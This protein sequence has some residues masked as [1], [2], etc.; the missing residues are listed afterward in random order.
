MYCQSGD[1]GCMCDVAC[2]ES[3]DCCED[4]HDIKCFGKHSTQYDLGGCKIDRGWR[5]GIVGVAGDCTHSTC[6]PV[7]APALP[8]QPA[9]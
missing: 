6:L 3:G 1:G 7:P 8:M 9:E 5:L 2:H 4:I